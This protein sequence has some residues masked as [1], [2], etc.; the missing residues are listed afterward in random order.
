M[1]G[2]PPSWPLFSPGGSAVVRTDVAI[3]LVSFG[4]FHRIVHSWNE[5]QIAFKSSLSPIWRE[6]TPTVRYRIERARN[7][8]QIYP[9][10]PTCLKCEVS[11]K[12]NKRPAEIQRGSCIS[13]SKHNW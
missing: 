10:A 8:S 13:A 2:M 3:Y 7:K 6:R 11:Q 1:R 12:S 4:T 5:C 9:H